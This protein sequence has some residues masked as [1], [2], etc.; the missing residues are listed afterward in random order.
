MS[1]INWE[2]K[3]R[4]LDKETSEKLVTNYRFVSRLQA[5]DGFLNQSVHCPTCGASGDSFDTLVFWLDPKDHLGEK[6][7][8]SWSKK[9]KTVTCGD[10]GTIYRCRVMPMTIETRVTVVG[11]IPDAAQTGEKKP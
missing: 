5:I 9:C 2:R 3:F 1:K 4:D 7:I 8:A 11:D 6:R 10:C